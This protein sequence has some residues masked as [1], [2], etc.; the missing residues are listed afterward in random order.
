MVKVKKSEVMR[1][2]KTIKTDTVEYKIHRED[3][4]DS[5]KL[6]RNNHR[7][8][9]GVLDDIIKKKEEEYGKLVL[10]RNLLKSIDNQVLLQLID[11]DEKKSM[12]KEALKREPI[13]ETQYTED[14]CLKNIEQ[15]LQKTQYQSQ[16]ENIEKIL[17]MFEE[18]KILSREIEDLEENINNYFLLF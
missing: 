8:I 6:C 14:Q 7:L 11:S 9:P 10:R 3:N 1:G 5:I 15:L 17:K 4:N 13:N 2:K 18:E 12:L 16:K